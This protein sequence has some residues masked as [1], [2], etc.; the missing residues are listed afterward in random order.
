MN[1]TIS[2]L[3]GLGNKNIVFNLTNHN[4]SNEEN[5]AR[6]NLA[7]VAIMG[8]RLSSAEIRVLDSENHKHNIFFIKFNKSEMAIQTL[9]NSFSKAF[10]L[11]DILTNVEEVSESMFQRL[12]IKGVHLENVAYNE[13][14]HKVQ[15]V[16]E[17]QAKTAASQRFAFYQQNFVAHEIVSYFELNKKD[18]NFSAL[19][20]QI[21]EKIKASMN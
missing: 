7:G 12:G 4:L 20:L 10:G 6:E 9:A 11:N 14:N 15:S 1:Q 3:N 18:G 17:G 8:G 13:L 2:S 16:A 21:V 19:E 5:E